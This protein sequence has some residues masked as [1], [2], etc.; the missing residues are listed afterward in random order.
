MIKPV[1]FLIAWSCLP[2]ARAQLAPPACSD[3]RCIQ[4]GSYNIEFM[5]GVRDPLDGAPRGPRTDDQI[6]R[7]ADRVSKD[8]DLEV[9]AFQEI[10]THSDEWKEFK[11]LLEPQGYKFFEGATSDR[12]QFVVLAWDADEVTLLDDSAGE[13]DVPNR[14]DFGDG[15]LEQ[16]LRKPV[17]ARFR[18]GAFDFWIVGV[19]LKSRR[20]EATCS[21]RVRAQQC[22]DLV[23]AADELIRTT[24]ERDVLLVGDFNNRPGHATLAAL[25]EAGFVTQM[26]FLMPESA[27]GSFVKTMERH[28]TVDLIDQVM[29]RPGDVRE[30]MPKSACIM[31]LPSRD[32]ATA[33]IMEQSDHAPAWSSFRTDADLDDDR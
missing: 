27:K 25:A 11:K 18:A 9:I 23:K 20:G 28:E 12:N 8:L 29:L 10:N 17:A 6:Q 7:L 22:R 30:A 16:G 14:F 33:Y 5:G 31:R 13:L 24:G 19:H 32:E 26:Q 2:A 15:C 21:D 3:G 1:C 4:V